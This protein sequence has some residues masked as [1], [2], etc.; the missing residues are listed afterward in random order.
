MNTLEKAQTGAELEI[1]NKPESE[2]TLNLA[3]AS[4]Q[5]IASLQGQ[6][7]AI[8]KLAQILLV[9]VTNKMGESQLIVVSLSPILRRRID[10]QQALLKS[11]ESL[12]NFLVESEANPNF[13]TVVPAPLGTKIV[14]VDDTS[15]LKPE[16][17]PASLQPPSN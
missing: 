6:P 3:Q 14:S 17:P 15:S 9:K 10:E 7:N 13:K 5:L 8:I 2:A 1:L 12:F 16:L 4:A 11:P